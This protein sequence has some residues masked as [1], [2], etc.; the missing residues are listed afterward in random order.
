MATDPRATKLWKRFT[1]SYGTRFTEAYGAKPTEAWIEAIDA[2]TDEQIAYGTK[3]VMRESPIHPPA[4]GQFVQASAN[5]PIAQIAKGPTIQEQLLEYAALKLHGKIKPW[6]YS[7]PWTYVYREWWDSTRPRGFERCAECTGVV[8][9]LDDD[10]RLGFSV[11]EML[12]DAE[13][14][15]KA[16]GMFRPGPSP[17]EAQIRAYHGIFPGNDLKGSAP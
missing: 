11:V 15:A 6:E 13:G 7:R 12:G 17:T 3:V 5:M 10:T 8:I 14:H 9:D 1:Q 4:L 16:M 2:L